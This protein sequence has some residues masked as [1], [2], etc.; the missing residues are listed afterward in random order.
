MKAILLTFF[1]L[2]TTSYAEDAAQETDKKKPDLLVAK[3]G[4]PAGN[5]TPEGVTCDLV[6]S[7][8]SADFELFKKTCISPFGG[9]ENKKAYQEFIED[10]RA[11]MKAESKKESPSP[12]GPKRIAKLYAARHLSLNGPASM[13]YAVFDFHDIMFVDVL[14]ELVSGE[15]HLNRTMVIKKKDGSWHVHPAPHTAS[16]LSKGLN[17]EKASTIDFTEVYSIAQKK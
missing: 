17:D 3:D 4:F 13:G 11:N 5:T 14:V 7:F 10:I 6:R 8:I 9:G 15:Q 16:L 1:A 12:G 2:L